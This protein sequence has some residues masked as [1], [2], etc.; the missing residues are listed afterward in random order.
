MK[1]NRIAGILK[2]FIICLVLIT[3]SA[4]A[5]AQRRGNDRDNRYRNDRD[6]RDREDKH[7]YK[8]NRGRHYHYTVPENGRERIIYPRAPWGT[9]QPYFVSHNRGRLYFY[10]GHYYEYYPSRGYVIIEAPVGYE[11]DAVPSG[12]TRVWIDN[13]WC[14]RRGDLYLRPSAHG[15]ISFSRPGFRIGASF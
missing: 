15:Y 3:G 12:F 10:R 11:F 9:R 4:S 7:Y 6:N 13:T 14:Y 8:E 5:F 1:T 2:M